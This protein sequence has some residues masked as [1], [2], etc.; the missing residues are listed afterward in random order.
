MDTLLSPRRRT[1]LHARG[2]ATLL[3]ACGEQRWT[4][5]VRALEFCGLTMGSIYTVKIAGVVLSPT[6]Q[7]TARDAQR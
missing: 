7:A 1:F 6:A 4:P 5:M 3:T 2:A